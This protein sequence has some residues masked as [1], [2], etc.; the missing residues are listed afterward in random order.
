M[1]MLNA[2][3]VCSSVF[4]MTSVC[5]ILCYRSKSSHIARSV[6]LHTPP[7][8]TLAVLM[9]SCPLIFRCFAFC[10]Q[11]MFSVLTRN[12][13]PIRHSPSPCSSYVNIPP[14][15]TAHFASISPLLSTPCASFKSPSSTS[16]AHL[17][18]SSTS[19]FPDINIEVGHALSFKQSDPALQSSPLLPYL[20]TLGD[21]KDPFPPP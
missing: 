7:S 8:L 20:P 4:S 6:T 18:F 11:L 17:R 16:C 15:L 19:Q 14:S 10:P 2:S 3:S 13:T 12:M 5:D 21:R 9:V 1:E